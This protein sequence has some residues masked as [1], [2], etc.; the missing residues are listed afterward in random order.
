MGNMVGQMG[1]ERNG[2]KGRNKKEK[3]KKFTMMTCIHSTTLYRVVY[4][5]KI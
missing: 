3:I 1:S 2:R 5:V 4:N